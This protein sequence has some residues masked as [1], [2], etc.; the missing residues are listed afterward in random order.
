MFGI[1]PKFSLGRVVIAR[2]AQ[3]RLNPG[4]VAPALKRHACGDWGD[5]CAQDILSSRP[6]SSSRGRWL[7]VRRPP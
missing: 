6:R 2:N 5:C 7:P 1:K 4:D 3:E